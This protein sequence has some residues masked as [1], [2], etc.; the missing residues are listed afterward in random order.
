MTSETK[1]K[2]ISLKRRKRASVQA[3]PHAQGGHIVIVGGN[4]AMGSLFARLFKENR[5]QVKILEQHNQSEAHT[6][7]AGARAVIVAVPISDTC[8]VVEALPALPVDCL[9]ADI[10]SFKRAPLT[11][12]LKKHSGPVIGL[13][14]MFGPDIDR[15]DGQLI[16]H[17]PGRKAKQ[18]QWLLEILSAWGARLIEA[19]AEEH[20]NNMAFVQG[21]RHFVF[22]SLGMAMM[23][24]KPEPARL[25]AMAT[26]SFQIDMM[27]VGRMFSQDARLYADIFMSSADNLSLIKKYYA[28]LVELLAVL[29]SGDKA[30]F[31]RIFL[32]VRNWLGEQAVPLNRQSVALRQQQALWQNKF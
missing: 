18:C 5:F 25:L 29:E 22:F 24:E 20:D 19:D 26:P 3:P 2:I 6:M 21:L 13:H 30:E 10:T 1:N 14:P 4:G 12:M 31:E 7:L 23:R 11:A 27:Q 16:I 9:L 8:R 17:C 32:K 28:G 15:M